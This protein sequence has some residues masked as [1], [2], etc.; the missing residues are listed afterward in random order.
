LRIGAQAIEQARAS[1]RDHVKLL[2]LLARRLKDGKPSLEH[3]Q[4]TP[5]VAQAAL[6]K[7][8]VGV[9]SRSLTRVARSWPVRVI[10]GYP[11][12]VPA[13]EFVMYDQDRRGG[14]FACIARAYGVNQKRLR[15]AARMGCFPVH[16]VGR[17]TVITY[18][19]FEKW[20]ARLP[21]PRPI[22]KDPPFPPQEA[23]N[24]RPN[25]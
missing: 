18:T 12:L 2:S 16:Q 14:N 7:A 10:S 11:P 1:D 20:L 3:S 19:E 6:P 23:P 25:D 21:P 9:F 8:Q 22:R 5:K 15:L 4:H 13:S 24:D 17:K